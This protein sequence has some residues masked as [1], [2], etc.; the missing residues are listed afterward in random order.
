[1]TQNL[2]YSVAI[3][4]YFSIIRYQGARSHFSGQLLKREG[5]QN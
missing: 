2:Y 1:M 4:I 3:T 5:E